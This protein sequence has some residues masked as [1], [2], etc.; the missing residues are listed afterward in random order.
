MRPAI[1]VAL[2]LLVLFLVFFAYVVV[3][4]LNA[5]D[6]AA[7][8][9]RDLALA[10]KVETACLAYMT[11]YNRLPPSSDNQKLAAALLGANARLIT[12]VAFSKRELNT[13]QEIVDRWGTPLQITFQGASTI[14]VISAGPDKTFGT[15]D[16]IVSNN[17]ANSPQH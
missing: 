15:P 4:S 10:A 16:D 11:E 1:K 7:N 13:N 6:A 12:F 14:Q 9:R 3:Q 5:V 2:A 8:S 17:P